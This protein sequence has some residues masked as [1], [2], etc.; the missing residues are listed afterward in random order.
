V[1]RFDFTAHPSGPPAVASVTV[2]PSPDTLLVG[3]AVQL[4]ATTKDSAG[5]VLTQRAVTWASSDT[6]KVKVSSAGLAMSVAVGSA[7]IT[8]TSQGKSGTAAITSVARFAILPNPIVLT[9]GTTDNLIYVVARDAHG[10]RV[11]YDP[12]ELTLVSSD[13]SV[14]APSVGGCVDGDCGIDHLIVVAGHPGTATITASLVT[15][16]GT[17]VATASAT[18]NPAVT[19]EIAFTSDRDGTEQIYMMY[20]DGSSPTRLTN[21]P[22]NNRNA[23]WSPDGKRIAFA[24][25]CDGN[26]EIYVMNA[27]GSSPARLTNNPATDDQ[28]AWSPDGKKIAFTSMGEV[29]VM[30]ADGSSPAR[31]TYSRLDASSAG[32]AAWSPDGS[33]IASAVIHRA[34]AAAA[35]PVGQLIDVDPVP[36]VALLAL[37]PPIAHDDAIHAGR[38]EIVQPLRL[39]PF[40]EGDVNRAPHAAEELHERRC[41]RRQDAARDHAAA[42]LADRGQGGCL[43]HVQRHMFGGLFHESRSLLGSMRSRHFHGSSKGRALNMR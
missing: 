25:D 29:Y 17:L 18:V 40:L 22:A 24:S 30:N 14:A 34:Q 35:Q 12:R 36:L 23:A 6:T 32:Q 43:M 42:V 3:S 1:Q 9:A 11:L 33:K 26:F 16:D 15:V 2:A 8:A 20:A 39:G 10:A 7:V 19:G 4:A 27:D 13:S 38:E 28:P 37:P 21:G 5:N 31:L 41:F